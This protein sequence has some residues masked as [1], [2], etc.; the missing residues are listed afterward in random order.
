MD[1]QTLFQIKL[2][3]FA[4]ATLLGANFLLNLSKMRGEKKG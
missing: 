4:I 1:A 2:A 3:L